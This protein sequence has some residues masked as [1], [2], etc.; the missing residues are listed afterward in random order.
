M[1]KKFCCKISVFLLL[2]LML[3]A[4]K[5]NNNISNENNN[6][7]TNISSGE[8]ISEGENQKEVDE[9]FV[10]KENPR[11]VAMSINSAKALRVLGYENVVGIP[12]GAES[13]YPEASIIGDANDPDFEIIK[14]LE[15]DILLTDKSMEYEKPLGEQINGVTYASASFENI[16]DTKQGLMY[17]AKGLGLN[18]EVVKEKID[19]LNENI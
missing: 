5:S 17:Y 14:N 4:C 13:I 19:A 12:K 7:N 2:M 6:P 15:S 10:S 8:N 11:V 18:E 3:V 9:R 1:N 16:D